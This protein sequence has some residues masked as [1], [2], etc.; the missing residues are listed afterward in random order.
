MQGEG[1][2]SGGG[3]LGKRVKEGE[4]GGCAFYTWV[5]EYGTPKPVS[6]FKKRGENNGGRNQPGY[7]IC[8]RGNV[9]MSPPV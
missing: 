2:K 3:E 4:Y 8:I 9:T 7:N 1:I 6:H 5:N